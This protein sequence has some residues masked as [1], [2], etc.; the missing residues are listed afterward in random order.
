MAS[1]TLSSGCAGRCGSNS[2]AD[3]EDSSRKELAP[4]SRPNLLSSAGDAL[5]E[6]MAAA[7]PLHITVQL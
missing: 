1:L 2:K 7:I 5:G 3:A 6:L 4:L